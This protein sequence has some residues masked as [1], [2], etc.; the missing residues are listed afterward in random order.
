VESPSIYDHTYEPKNSLSTNSP[1]Q[2]HLHPSSGAQA[3]S[4]PLSRTH[5][6]SYPTSATAIQP[7][8]R[9]QSIPADGDLSV[10]MRN[11]L[12]SGQSI[13]AEGAV[14]AYDPLDVDM[15]LQDNF[16]GSEAF[17]DLL[18]GWPTS[19]SDQALP[20]FADILGGCQCGSNCPCPG[21]AHNPNDSPIGV[22][23]SDTSRCPLLCSSCFDCVAGLTLSTGISSVDELLALA[24]NATPQGDSTSTS[25]EF[26]VA[27]YLP[28]SNR[29]ES[30]GKSDLGG[31][32]DGMGSDS[33]NALVSA[34]CK[35]KGVAGQPDHKV[36]AL[37]SRNNHHRVHAIKSSIHESLSNRKPGPVAK[38][39]PKVLSHLHTRHPAAKSSKPC[40]KPILPK[41]VPRID[42]GGSNATVSNVGPAPSNAP[43]N[44]NQLFISPDTPSMPPY[45]SGPYNPPAPFSDPSVSYLSNSPFQ[46]PPAASHSDT[47]YHPPRIPTFHPSVQG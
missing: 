6:S 32:S 5:S 17:S 18:R 43:T 21:C 42:G 13:A 36:F 11:A 9:S 3:T 38:P 31:D 24:S 20:S 7:P 28:A 44:P 15:Y 4:Q 37:E 41:L 30:E 45:N 1:D 12:F 10:E 46:L 22:D 26:N 27:S 8:V 47:L 34:M 16:F 23:G 35:E 40:Y 39:D 33:R 25:A 19:Q 2:C 29:P 14:A